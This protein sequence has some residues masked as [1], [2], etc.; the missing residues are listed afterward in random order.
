MSL[1][2]IVLP[3]TEPDTEWVRG[4]ALQK[5][6]PTTN[7]A[8]LQSALSAKLVAWAATRGVVGSEWRFR[9]GPPGEPLRPGAEIASANL[10]INAAN[11]LTMPC[12]RHIFAA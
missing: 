12:V 1:R 5:M 2:E 10:R 7:H 4:R 11:N 9:V 6:S 3:E 8:V